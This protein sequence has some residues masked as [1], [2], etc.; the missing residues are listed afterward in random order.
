MTTTNITVSGMTCGHCVSHVTQAL[1]GLAGVS[2]VSIELERGAVT[3]ESA[4]E[5][6]PAEITA[7]VVAAGYSVTA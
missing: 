5:L 1:E 2:G 3:I 6:D 7:A 4:A